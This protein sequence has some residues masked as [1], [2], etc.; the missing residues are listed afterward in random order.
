MQTALIAAQELGDEKM[1]ILQCITDKI[2]VKTRLLDQDFKNLDFGKE[3]TPA[4]EKQEVQP[5]SVN[6]CNSSV[7]VNA[8]KPAK[9]ARR[10]RHDTFT[11]MENSNLDSPAPEH[12]LRSSVGTTSSSAST[13]KKT[14][15]GKGMR[16]AVLN[17]FY[18]YLMKEMF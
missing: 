5:P 1:H 9:R 16:D 2:E 15:I 10:T 6:T 17:A 13:Q 14:N 8:D 12:V 18:F 7:A 11:G 4:I 3:E